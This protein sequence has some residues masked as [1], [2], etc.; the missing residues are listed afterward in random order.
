M[1]RQILGKETQLLRLEDEIMVLCVPYRDKLAESLDEIENRK[2]ELGV[3]G[4]NVSL[5][6]LEQVFLK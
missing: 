5:I 2:R 3:I 6:T 4:I 1:I